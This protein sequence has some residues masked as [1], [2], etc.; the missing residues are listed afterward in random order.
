MSHE[1][2]YL[3]FI[4]NSIDRL[5]SYTPRTKSAFMK[6]LAA[7]DGAVWRLQAIGDAARNHLSD[8]L[9]KRHPEIDWRAI[10]GFRNIAAHDYAELDL[11]LTWEIVDRHLAPLHKVLEFELRGER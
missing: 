10:Y 9:K 5:R 4:R 11:N 2:R 8:D 1:V 7:Q 3:W 6:N